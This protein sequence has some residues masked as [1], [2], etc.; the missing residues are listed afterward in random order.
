MVPYVGGFGVFF[1]FFWFGFFGLVACV[2]LAP[3]PEMKLRPSA[4]NMWSPNH[5]T[6]RLFALFKNPL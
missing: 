6:T 4:V 3:R 2:I 5:W 1:F